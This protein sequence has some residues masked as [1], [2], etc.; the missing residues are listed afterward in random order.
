[1]P[2]GKFNGRGFKA[3][4]SEIKLLKSNYFHWITQKRKDPIRSLQ[5]VERTMHL[6]NFYYKDILALDSFIKQ[7]LAEI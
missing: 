3:L 6:S 1:M 5:I 4:K 2:E 7:N